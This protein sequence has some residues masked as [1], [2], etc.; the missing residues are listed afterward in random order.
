MGQDTSDK[1]G[2]VPSDDMIFVIMDAD[3][4]LNE[5]AH[6][7]QLDLKPLDELFDAVV[8]RVRDMVL[9]AANG[10]KDKHQTSTESRVKEYFHMNGLLLSL[11]HWGNDIQVE[12]K[13]PLSI[14][15]KS[16]D[17]FN[18]LSLILRRKFLD[19]ML[20]C[21]LID[22]ATEGARQG[23]IDHLDQLSR[24]L[25]DFVA[26]LRTFLCLE[27]TLGRDD[28]NLKTVRE[29][30]CRL[31]PRRFG[32]IK[33]NDMKDNTSL[34]ERITRK[35][36]KSKFDTGPTR[37]FAPNGLIKGLIV[38][39][40]VRA[41]LAK[42]LAAGQN[43][44]DQ[45]LV[46]YIVFR[47]R[48]LFA[49]CLR[50]H[51]ENN[52]LLNAMVLFKENSMSDFDLPLEQTRLPPPVS[53][54]DHGDDE[55]DDDDWD[56]SSQESLGMKDTNVSSTSTK[57]FDSRLHEIDPNEKIWELARRL[58]FI[59]TE[60]WVFLAPVFSTKDDNQDLRKSSVLPFQMRGK[61]NVGGGFGIVSEI[62]VRAGH[63][64]DPDNL[65]GSKMPSSYALKQIRPN[66]SDHQKVINNWTKELA[67][68]RSVTR[69]KHPNILRFVTA[70]RRGDGELRDHYLICE[71][72]DGGSLRD[73]WND[74]KSPETTPGLVKEVVAQ[75]LGLADALCTLHYS[76]ELKEGIVHGDLK[77]E[78]I[79]RFRPEGGGPGLLGTL[80]IGDWGL[81]KEK[82]C[83]TADQNNASIYRASIR[84]EP[85][86]M[87]EGVFVV[88]RNT[89]LKT[90]SRLYD[91]WS[92]GCIMLEFIVWLA[93]GTV[94][95]KNLE[96][97][98]GGSGNNQFWEKRLGAR[99]DVNAQ[100]QVRASIS[101][102]MDE[103]DNQA[104]CKIVALKKLLHF[105]RNRALVV[106][107]P[108]YLA[109]L[110]PDELA[111][112]NAADAELYGPTHG[113]RD[114]PA[115]G[116]FGFSRAQTVDF[117]NSINS[118][119]SENPHAEAAEIV[120]EP[121]QPPSSSANLKSR[122]TPEG[123][124]TIE[125]TGPDSAPTPTARLKVAEPNESPRAKATELLKTMRD[126]MGL[127]A[128]QAGSYPAGSS[129]IAPAKQPV[130]ATSAGETTATTA[131]TPPSLVFSDNT[132]TM[133]SVETAPSVPKVYLDSGDVAA[134]Q[135]DSLKI[136]GGVSKPG[137]LGV[138]GPE[139]VGD[140]PE[141]PS[142][143]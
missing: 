66:E 123:K 104:V 129:T 14:T 101:R 81:S 30:A 117:I 23:S 12:N 68:L 52:A 74:H 100:L 99:L 120:E 90:R 89:L 114:E 107:L 35:L 95:L 87:S 22:K 109:A 140:D 2:A 88:G 25:R 115:E 39:D 110:E 69:L 33:G 9:L 86:E 56:R 27:D 15:E 64:K 132:A 116:G 44:V 135:D 38:P 133:S 92:F 71:W 7:H 93:E 41:T 34:V 13:S 121:P 5:D 45:D 72:A 130:W 124:P 26:P 55:S 61:K 127:A 47:A 43:E 32:R 62:K 137:S 51:L 126:I 28:A 122:S 53:K 50:Q 98:L 128:D 76:P 19:I 36:D 48:N 60:Q 46:D 138:P 67:N 102:K 49:I 63:M 42:G 108:T 70:F 112:L 4:A 141:R 75:L 24:Q 73:F 54:D 3:E 84:Y 91:I 134:P 85:P 80:K 136:P 96:T 83:K 40:D 103:L 113:P 17:G 11:Q 58:S 142:L 57:N 78:N 29:A 97:L 82:E 143:H 106:H 18:S 59:E 31:D 77:P 6:L 37:K 65:F 139:N 21:S 125:V 20:A 131:S 111:R 16:N 119:D 94:G 118:Y 8:N 1:S 10:L 105:V 79:L